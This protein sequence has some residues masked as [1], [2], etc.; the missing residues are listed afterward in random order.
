MNEQP[1]YASV[2][3]RLPIQMRDIIRRDAVANRRSFNA[4]VL[5]LLESVVRSAEGNSK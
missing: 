2:S 5:T 1:T 4:Q 3:L